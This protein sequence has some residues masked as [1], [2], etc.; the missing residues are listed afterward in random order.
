MKRIAIYV[1][2]EKSGKVLNFEKF[3]ISELLKDFSKVIV[4]ANGE[5]D[6]NQLTGFEN[7]EIVRRENKGYDFG[8]WKDV[9]IKRYEREIKDYDQL[10]ITNNSIY[11]P[12]GSFSGMIAEMDKRNCDFW[13]INRHPAKDCCIIKGDNATR[14]YEH[15]Q[16]YWI[17]FKSRLLCSE[18]F[19]SYW[20]NLPELDTFKKAIGYGEVRLTHHFEQLGYISDSFADFKKYSSL[21]DLNPCFFTYEQVK[22]DCIPVIKRK[23]F[24]DYFEQA[25][26]FNIELKARQLL[27]YLSSSGVYSVDYIMEDLYS[28]AGFKQ[29]FH[30]LG[31]FRSLPDKADIAKK[32]CFKT[33]LMLVINDQSNR[34][35][36]HD[37][38]KMLASDWNLVVVKTAVELDDNVVPLT[39]LSNEDF[40]S[41]SEQEP[42]GLVIINSLEDCSVSSLC[43]ITDELHKL[44]P[45]LRTSV[46]SEIFA[47]NS[48]PSLLVPFPKVSGEFSNLSIHAENFIQPVVYC[49]GRNNIIYAFVKSLL[50]NDIG[51]TN[52]TFLEQE[53]RAAE[54]LNENC[55]YAEYFTSRGEELVSEMY[56]QL[57][58]VHQSTSDVEILSKIERQIKRIKRN[59]LFAA[60]FRW[61][62]EYYKLKNRRHMKMI[63]EL[64]RYR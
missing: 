1:H 42:V 43:H 25:I 47:Q 21:S 3:F 39:Y 34:D 13:G 17:V 40:E 59:N 31:L 9:I 49:Y 45:V 62:K 30:S 52:G 54:I 24:Y 44:A 41:G 58:N 63:E 57:G 19:I 51:F 29:I 60:I 55:C 11:G 15:L 23:Y 8:A 14:C 46:V 37:W 36:V 10:L 26:S 7:V 61:K 48:G 64:L 22:N 20:R 56:Y 53:A 6:K 12:L 18:D 35:A 50:N 28:V 32:T 16:S 5:I 33:K 4:V 2:Y 38:L 27:D